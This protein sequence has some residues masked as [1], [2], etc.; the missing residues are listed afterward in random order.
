M[1]FLALVEVVEHDD[2]PSRFEI[3]P[4]TEAEGGGYLMLV[5]SLG[6]RSVDNHEPR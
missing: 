3:R 2:D 1:K 4:L 6:R 5:E